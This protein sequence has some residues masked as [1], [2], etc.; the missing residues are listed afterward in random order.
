MLFQLEEDAFSP[1]FVEVS[2]S[3]QVMV[4]K[5]RIETPSDKHLRAFTLEYAEMGIQFPGVMAQ[6]RL[7]ATD[8]PVVS[9]N[10]MPSF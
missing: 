10:L 5:L 9:E 1:Q 4:N 3:K 7:G 8:S 2:M 6:Q